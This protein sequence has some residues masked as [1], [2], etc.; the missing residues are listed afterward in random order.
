MKKR[1]LI[2]YSGFVGSNLLEQCEFDLKY[3]SKN[4]RE[5]KVQSF[6]EIICAGVSAVKWQANKEP[7]LDK[8]RIQELMDVLSTVSA[9]RFV[10][11]STIDV[12]PSRQGHDEDFDCHSLPNHA[13]GSNRLYF[14]DFCLKT[15]PK[16]HILRLPGLFG[17]GLKKNIIYDLLNKNGLEM[18]NPRSSYQYYYLKN[19]WADIQKAIN[20]DIRIMN[21]FTAPICTKEIVDKFFEDTVYGSNPSPEGHYDLHTK[22]GSSGNYRYSRK[23]VFAHLQEFIEGYTGKAK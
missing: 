6:S 14:E 4:F 23:N 2:G 15:F 7:E 20:E 3:N 8:K 16:C 9:S 12:Y 5:M 19:L 13:Y 21:L 11:I 17:K 1:A 22:Y 18:I 10:L